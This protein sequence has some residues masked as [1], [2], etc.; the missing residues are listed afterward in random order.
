MN[1]VSLYLLM[2]VRWFPTRSHIC[3]YIDW[4]KLNRIKYTSLTYTKVKIDY[5]RR[6][7]GCPVISNTEIKHHMYG[8]LVV[9]CHIY[10]SDDI[11]NVLYVQLWHVVI[12]AARTSPPA[13][14]PRQSSFSQTPQA[15]K[16]KGHG[17]VSG[18]DNTILR[19][20]GYWYRS[21]RLI[22]VNQI[23][24]NYW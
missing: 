14:R 22:I 20:A 4:S 19:R 11:Y 1:G 12:M 2:L 21:S 24:I 5:S 15:G 9:Y 7:Q 23:S 16:E 6:C 17:S 3:L 13:A 18:A 10:K 8:F